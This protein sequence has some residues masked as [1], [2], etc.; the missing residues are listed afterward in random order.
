M[1]TASDGL[2]A[3][4]AGDWTQEKLY[5]VQ[6]YC[7]AFMIAMAPK[8]AQRRWESLVY[9]DLLSGPGICINRESGAE[10]YGS[11]LL[12]L[13]INPPFDKFYFR[14]SDQDTFRAL[15]GRLKGLG[16]LSIDA[17]SGDCNNAVREIVQQ[18][19][20]KTLSVAF[21]D[22]E[23]LEVQF[24][25]FKH[26]AQRKV[27]VIYLFPTGGIVRN[28]HNFVKSPSLMDAFW[29]GSDW[30][31]L[32]PGTERTEETAAGRSWVKSF[33][34]KMQGLGFRSPGDVEPPVINDQN[35]RMFHL[36]FFSQDEAG[37]KIWRGIKQIEARGQRRLKL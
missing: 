25:T 6:R 10:F 7:Q 18:L 2:E 31:R 32:L 11:P 15:D 17:K 16:E 21:L 28:V 8:R 27:D 3:R 37:L 29:G 9:I 12:A 22:P 4:L 20:P 5:Y 36:L 24:Q 14:E 30:R 1:P 35:A 33:Q 13:R 23:G 34:T 26:L 19:S